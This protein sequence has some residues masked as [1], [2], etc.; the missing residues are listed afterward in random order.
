MLGL[1]NSIIGG[2][3]LGTPALTPSDISGLDVWLQ[4]NKGIAG[5]S[6]TSDDGNM[7]DGEQIVSW[8]DQSGNSNHASDI[9]SAAQRPVWE[10]DAADFG[11][12]K[13]D[14]TD[15]GMDFNSDITITANQDFTIMIR[16]KVTDLTTNSALYGNNS[17][18]VLKISGANTGKQLTTLIGGSGG[19]HFTEASDTL[20]NNKYYIVTLTRSNGSDGDLNL[21]VHGDAFTDK[22]WGSGAGNQDSDA[23]TIDHLAVHSGNSLSMEGVIK[24]F[25]VWKGTALSDSERAD[26]YT[27]ILAQDY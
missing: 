7:V 19:K 6:N 11:G 12:A 14:G 3:A 23:F 10:T 2:A 13:F 18:N 8:A 5:A 17:Q 25:L 20:L 22:D 27:Y 16:A 21:R 1:T 24:D 4:V 15:D 9:N 26:M